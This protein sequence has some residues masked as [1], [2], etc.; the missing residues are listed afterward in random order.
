[1]VKSR[2][3]WPLLAMAVAMALLATGCGGGGGGET[4]PAES[5]P[6][7]TI[8]PETL[9][10]SR[11]IQ[12]AAAQSAEA[13]SM[14]GDMAVGLHN[15]PELDTLEMRW[16]MEWNINGDT[17]VSIDLSDLPGSGGDLVMETRDVDGI[18][19][20]PSWAMEGMYRA[21]SPWVSF[22]NEEFEEW[23]GADLGPLEQ[24]ESNAAGM[25]NFLDGLTDVEYVGRETIDDMATSHYRGTQS[26]A[27]LLESS[28]VGTQ[29]EKD[30]AVDSLM[31]LVGDVGGLDIGAMRFDYEVWIDSEDYV[32]RLN[33][34]VDDLTS[35]FSDEARDELDDA[36]WKILSE[37]TM[38][39]ESTYYDYGA[40]IEIEAPPASEVTPFSELESRFLSTDEAL[41]RLGVDDVDSL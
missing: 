29:E 24:M 37:A 12:L 11:S 20:V 26:V 34:Y 3:L 6:Q 32:R 27:E 13:T 35:M 7:A 4:S 5:E 23:T 16:E 1:M 28:I 17:V 33:L 22:T 40:A 30:A 8:S 39:M 21:T 19:Y 18:Y 38:S 10:L 14:R 25:F 31:S 2:I 9:D 15:V 36:A 41:E